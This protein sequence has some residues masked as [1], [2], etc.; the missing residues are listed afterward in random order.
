M[1]D[2]NYW[3]DFSIEVSAPNHTAACQRAWALLSGPDSFLPIGTVTDKIGDQE[4]IDLQEL[5]DETEAED[6]PRLT[7]TLYDENS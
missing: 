3:V 2:K 5:A 4:T 7:T 6:D 1:P